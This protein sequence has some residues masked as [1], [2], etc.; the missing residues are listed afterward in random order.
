LATVN[1]RAPK[2]HARNG[3]EEIG[4]N[5]TAPTVTRIYMPNGAPPQKSVGQTA[6]HSEGGALLRPALCA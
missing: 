6:S 2:F 1:F 5:Q 3:R 4:G